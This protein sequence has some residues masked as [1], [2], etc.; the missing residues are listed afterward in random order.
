[1]NY[2]SST[3]SVISLKSAVLKI[4]LILLLIFCLLLPLGCGKKG[5]PTAPLN[6]KAEMTLTELSGFEKNKSNG[7]IEN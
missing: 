7:L 4:F 6:M 3:D 1:M 5:P 2:T